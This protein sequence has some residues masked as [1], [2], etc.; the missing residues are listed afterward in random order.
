MEGLIL[1]EC[2]VCA[3]REGPFETIAHARYA[4]ARHEGAKAGHW[5]KVLPAPTPETVL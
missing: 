2:R 1:A 3:W 5:A 4:A